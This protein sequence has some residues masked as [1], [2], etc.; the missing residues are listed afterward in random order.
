MFE[1]V[2]THKKVYK[3]CNWRK[4]Q[5]DKTKNPRFCHLLQEETNWAFSIAPE[6]IQVST[7]TTG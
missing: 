3:I 5:D 2:F 4:K 1:A 6:P 7:H